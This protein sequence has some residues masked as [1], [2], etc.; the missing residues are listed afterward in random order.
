[1]RIVF[2]GD[3]N[4]RAGRH[5][6]MTQ[7]PR[8]IARR[9]IE[10]KARVI[11]VD[12]HAEA[13]SEKTAMGHYLDGRVTAV[14]GTHTHVQTADETIL[15]GGTGYITDLGM[16]GAYDSVIGI[17]KALALKKFLTGLPVRLTTAKRDPRMCGIILEVDETSGH[18]L[19]IERIQVRPDGDA[20][21]ADDA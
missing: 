3:V 20:S 14:V 12:M 4:G 19:A 9:G 21:G 15:P 13:T 1:M 11:L 18:A 6:L 10:A 5:V 8:L 2:L 17:D 7:L 16:T